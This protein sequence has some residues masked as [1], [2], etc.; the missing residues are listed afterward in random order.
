MANTDF[1]LSSYKMRMKI[2][3]YF[4]RML[5]MTANTFKNWKMLYISIWVCVMLQLDQNTTPLDLYQ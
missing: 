4:S 3:I 2:L 1:S 5:E